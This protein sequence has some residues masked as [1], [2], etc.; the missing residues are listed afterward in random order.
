MAEV[1]ILPSFS[2][3]PRYFSLVIWADSQCREFLFSAKL[4]LMRGV[5]VR[6]KLKRS[7]RT[8]T[9]LAEHFGRKI[10]YATRLMA[11][12]ELLPSE[13]DAVEAFFHGAAAAAGGPA[14]LRVPVYGYASAANGDHISLAEGRVLDEI[15]LPSG[16]VR[17][18]VMA[19][20]VVGD[21][22]EPRMFSGELVIVAK[23]VAPARYGDCVVELMDGSAL[24]KQY[25]GRRDG[26]VWLYQFNPEREFAIDAV[27]V[28]TI[29]AVAWRR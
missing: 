28:R 24:V 2:R 1:T 6:E 14:P 27:E 22:M 23:D 7:G 11:K 17:G 26:K 19:I 9:A 15:E 29:H 21:S 18:D 10:D 20:R 13:A 8:K 4:P 3:F 25:R 16:M 12:S 5:D